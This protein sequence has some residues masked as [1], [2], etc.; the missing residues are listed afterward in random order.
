MTRAA[1]EKE[2]E[3]RRAHFRHPV[4]ENGQ[5]VFEACR[6]YVFFHHVKANENGNTREKKRKLATKGHEQTRKIYKT[7][8]SA[9]S[10]SFPKF[11]KMES[12]KP[13]AL[14]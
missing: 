10:L 13:V 2:S 1:F 8:L 11:N 9:S 3:C 5:A 12:F 7:S 4:G 6:L 14:R